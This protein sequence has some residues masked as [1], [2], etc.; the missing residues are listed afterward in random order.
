MTRCRDCALYDLAAV[1]DKAGRVRSNRVARCLWVSN[2][3]LP[4]SVRNDQRRPILP[5]YMEPN[6]GEGCFCFKERAK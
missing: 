6:D 3:P 4:A 1:Q 5:S 2:E